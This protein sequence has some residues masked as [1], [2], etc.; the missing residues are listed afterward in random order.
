LGKEQKVRDAFAVALLVFFLIVAFAGLY[1]LDRGNRS[2]FATV[3]SV[4]GITGGM[5]A[6][7]VAV[8]LILG[9]GER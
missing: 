9:D 7:V 6:M 5:V 8:L 2:T 1:M 3:A 4:A